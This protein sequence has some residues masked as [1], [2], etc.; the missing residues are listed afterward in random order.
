MRSLSVLFVCCFCVSARGEGEAKS[1]KTRFTPREDPKLLPERFRL[2]AYEFAWKLKAQY[3]LPVSGVEVSSLTFPSPVKCKWECNNTVHAEYYRPTGKKEPVPGI[4]I[5]DILGGDQKLSRGLALHFAQNGVGALFVQMAY[6]G[7]RRPPEGVRLLTPDID[8]TMEGIRQT[9][10]DCRCAA[11]W[12]EAQP[13][14]DP[15]R[16]GML[17]TSLG[18]FM[19]ALT[20][21]M[22][23]R[24]EKVALFLGGG[25]L[26][27]AYWDHPKAKPYVAWGD[28]LP[29][30]KERMKALIAPVDPITYADRLK[31]HQLLMIAARRDDVVPP[32][33]AK[34]LWEAT[35]K[36]KIVWFDTNHVGAAFYLFEGMDAV[37]KHFLKE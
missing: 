4:L 25:G 16:L 36:Q 30:A 18:S 28:L 29:G 9:V 37:L 14:I 20:A 24:L 23:P 26:V 11:A 21:S 15:K 12:L 27:D 17:G 19:T 35:G 3:D 22:E 10:L 5:L 2:D 6:Y 31:T 13:E 8:H 34:S 33:A 7:P 1:G 32:A